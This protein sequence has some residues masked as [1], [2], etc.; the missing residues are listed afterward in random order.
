M[1]ADIRE[2][3]TDRFR[4]DASTLRERANALQASKKPVV[5]PDA[6]LSFAMAHACEE[7]AALAELLPE[8]ASL[9]AMMV[10]L[11]TLLPTLN[12]RANDPALAKTPAV[13][14]VYAGAATR[15]QEVIA[16]EARAAEAESVGGVDDEE[17]SEDEFGDD[18]ID[19]DDIDDD[20]I[21]SG[22]PEEKNDR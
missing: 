10:A 19:D 5:G 15:V 20:D 13:R 21:F 11:N 16:A 3:L 12:A 18:E 2:Y 7:V 9:D 8:H 4:S 6:A 17:L 1:S 14:A 22:H